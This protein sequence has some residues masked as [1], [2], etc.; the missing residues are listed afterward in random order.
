[1]EDDHLAFAVSEGVSRNYVSDYMCKDFEVVGRSMKLLMCIVKIANPTLY[2]FLNNA[3]IEPFFATS[4]LI[5][6]FAHDVKTIEVVARLY[7]VL[8]CSHPIF[9]FYICAAVR[10]LNNIQYYCYY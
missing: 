7:D 8:L 4:W 5:T 9:I 6:W 3:K 10:K 2:K 1:M